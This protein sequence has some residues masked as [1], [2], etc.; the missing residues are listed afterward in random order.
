MSPRPSGGE[1]TMTMCEGVRQVAGADQD[2]AAARQRLPDPAG[3]LE[4]IL[5]G[6]GMAVAQCQWIGDKAYRPAVDA[7]QLAG[8]LH[9]A[10]VAPDGLLRNAQS[11]CDVD[12]VH[13]ALGGQQ[14]S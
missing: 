2:G 14:V 8:D 4:V 9:G 12:N 7:L 10:Q 5:D 6:R 3:E 1:L 13:P 11:V